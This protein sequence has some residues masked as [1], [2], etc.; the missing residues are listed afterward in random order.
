[1]P[2][3][4]PPAMFVADALGLD[5]LNSIATPVDTPVEW[6]ADGEDL[7]AWLKQA[8]LLPAKVAASRKKSATPGELDAA[9][10][11]ARALR[12][13]FRRF[14]SEHK[15]EP[16]PSAAL[17]HLGPLNRILARDEE[18]GQIV[19]RDQASHAGHDHNA[20]SGLAWLRQKRW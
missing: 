15:G 16:V 1:M 11:P 14:V 19:V 13:W 20:V 8:G 3:N 5:F 6:L 9:A 12:E 17:R 10:A 4:R 2:D 7:L 18:F